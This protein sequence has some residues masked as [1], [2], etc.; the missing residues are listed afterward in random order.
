MGKNIRGFLKNLYECCFL[1]II[2]N[3]NSFN[4][5]KFEYYFEYYPE[6][7]LQVSYKEETKIDRRGY[8]IFSEKIAEVLF[9][10]RANH[11]CFSRLN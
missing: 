4:D 8:E 11:L 9:K 6:I 1:K 7:L 3:V 5:L 2:M 10:F